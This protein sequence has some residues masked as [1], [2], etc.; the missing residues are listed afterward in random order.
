MRNELMKKSQCIPDSFVGLG[1]S[2]IM[3]FIFII[4][5][6]I[7]WALDTLIRYPLLF[8]G[9]DAARIVFTEHL[10]LVLIFVPWLLREKS[11]TPAKFFFVVVKIVF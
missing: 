5:A 8:S 11:D 6:S 9:V 3:G 7:L 2:V 4:I 10:F 1:I